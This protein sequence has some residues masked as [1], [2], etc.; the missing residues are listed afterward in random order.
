MPKKPSGLSLILPENAMRALMNKRI[1][2][3]LIPGQSNLQIIPSITVSNAVGKPLQQ[4]TRKPLIF[5]KT[6]INVVVGFV[7][8][9]RSIHISKTVSCNKLFE[10]LQPQNKCT[11]FPI[12]NFRRLQNK[13]F[14]LLIWCYVPHKYSLHQTHLIHSN[15]P[16]DH[17]GVIIMTTISESTILICTVLFMLS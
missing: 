14:G 10:R 8:P 16:L 1:I 4:A 3:A 15:N 13:D 7:D 12:N 2:Q 9:K 17:L 5:L 11:F 6:I